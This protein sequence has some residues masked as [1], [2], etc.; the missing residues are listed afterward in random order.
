MKIYKNI[1]EKMISMDSLLSAWDDFKKGKRGKRDVQ[2]FEFR[3]EDNL[4]RLHRDLKNKRYK[5]GEYVDFYIRDPK[6]RHIHKAE[7]RDR[8]VHRVL[9]KYINPIFEPTFIADSYSTRI[10]KGTHKGVRRLTEFAQKIF[11]THGKCFV[12]KCD[13]KK[14]FP[15]IDHEALLSIINRRIKDPDVMWLIKIILGS[16]F[17]EFSAKGLK[18]APIGNLTSQLF[19]NIYL[20]KFDQFIKHKLKAKYYIRYCDDFVIFSDNRVTAGIRPH[21]QAKLWQARVCFLPV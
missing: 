21:R 13:I 8:V 6:V 5:H 20:N 15:T 17:S 19:A 3:L 10:G 16:F 2:E 11:Q 4:F 14:F 1:F 18:G 12:L 7:V 9:F